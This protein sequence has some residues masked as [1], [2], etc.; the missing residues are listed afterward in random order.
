M[1]P[2]APDLPITD[3]VLSSI[4]NECA[5]ELYELPDILK[6]H[7]LSQDY[8]ETVVRRHPRFMRFYA[9]AHAAWNSSAN[10][11][12]RSALKSAILFE[13]WL[14]ECNKLFLS[15]KEPLSSKLSLLRL[16][17]ET[18]KVIRKDEEKQGAAS[19]RVVININLGAGRALQVEK[20]I[21]DVTPEGNVIEAPK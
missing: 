12:E 1:V 4:A 19:D 16:M 21:R 11:R 18:G 7:G 2:L 20:E 6:K 13:Q 14:D 15:P 8:F 17:G 5:R 3:A 9:E 10:T